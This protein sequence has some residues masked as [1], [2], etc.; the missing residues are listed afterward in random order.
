[1]PKVKYFKTSKSTVISKS[2]NIINH[3]NENLN[4]HSQNIVYLLT[5][6]TCATQYTGETATPLHQR[7]NGHRTSKSGCEHII[8]HSKYSCEDHNFTYQILEK[9]PGSGYDQ[10]GNLDDEM[11]EIRLQCET[12]WILKLRTL[13]PYGLNEKLS[14]KIT[15]SSD[16]EYAVGRFIP[17]IPR[18]VERPIRSRT[19]DIL[20]VL[21]CQD[22]FNILQDLL[23][24]NLKESFNKITIILNNT[25]KRFLKEI[26]FAILNRD[27]NYTFLDNREQLYL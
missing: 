2:F 5:C 13:Y 8:N 24:N 20:N 22:F 6:F 23:T 10:N 18:T 21:S 27:D 14:G 11:T 1:M 4:C 15:N 12:A 17:S 26:A 19:R 25:K 16:L 7:M 3:T 9:L